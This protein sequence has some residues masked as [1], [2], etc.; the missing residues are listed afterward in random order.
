MLLNFVTSDNLTGTTAKQD[1][2][3]G[4]FRRQLDAYAGFEQ[5][6][7][8]DMQLEDTEAEQFLRGAHDTTPEFAECRHRIASLTSG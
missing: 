5:L 2:K 4:R 8:I 1:Q 3:L 7:G 6:F